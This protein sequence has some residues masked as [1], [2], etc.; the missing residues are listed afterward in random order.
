MKP[1]RLHLHLRPTSI[2]HLEREHIITK[3][4]ILNLRIA[5]AT[6]QDVM[7]VLADEHLF[8]VRQFL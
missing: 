5:L 2:D 8:A 1:I 6:S 3:D 7:D 4:E